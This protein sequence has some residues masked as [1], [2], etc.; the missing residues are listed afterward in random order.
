MP[1]RSRSWAA[2]ALVGVAAVAGIAF[3]ALRDRAP[4]AVPSG[5]VAI[6]AAAVAAKIETLLADPKVARDLED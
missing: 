2:V 6:P 1:S 5:P 3:W 4:A